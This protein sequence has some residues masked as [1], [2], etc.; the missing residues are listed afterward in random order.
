MKKS[1]EIILQMLEVSND[2]A[3][4]FAKISRIVGIVLL[5]SIVF[6]LEIS[7][8]RTIC[9]VISLI[10]MSLPFTF[11]FFID[12]H[13][14][15][16]LIK[17]LE[18]EITLKYKG[19]EPLYFSPKEIEKFGFKLTDY[20]GET[21]VVDMVNSVGRLNNRLGTGNKLSFSFKGETHSFNFKLK[22]NSQKKNVELMFQKYQ[23]QIIMK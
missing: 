8:I 17:L 14:Q 12:E 5:I 4:K 3:F 11:K 2:K 7:T 20:E 23:V 22:N 21:K 15:I 18:N 9:L 1:P 16:G 10:L 6:L 19:K 13:K